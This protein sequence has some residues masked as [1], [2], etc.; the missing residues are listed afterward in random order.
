MGADKSLLDFHGLPQRIYLFNLMKNFCDNVYLSLNESQ[1]LSANNNFPFV[2]DDPQFG[3][4][5]PM[6]ALLSYWKKYPESSVI[7]VGCDYPFIDSECIQYLIKNRKGAATCYINQNEN[8][9]EPLIA[10]YESSFLKIVSDNFRNKKY[11]LSKILKLENVSAIFPQS[12]YTLLN[13]NTPED[14]YSV[15]ELIKMKTV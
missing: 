4:I 9:Y 14:Y 2:K 13:V 10:I 12:E 15:K 7:A 8:I 3:D 11:S 6:T 1:V 5:G